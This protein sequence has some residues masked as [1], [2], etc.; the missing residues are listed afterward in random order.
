MKKKILFLLALLAPTGVGAQEA[1]QERSKAPELGM[2]LVEGEWQAPTPEGALRVLLDP[3][4]QSDPVAQIEPTTAV[5]RQVYE[6]YT[7]GEL[8]VVEEQ[9]VD[10]ILNGNEAQRKAA[11]LA[12]TV[13][14][15][16]EHD[17]PGIPYAGSRDAFI[18][19][20]DA[21][22]EQEYD[23]AR[24]YLA[25]IA[26]VGGIDYI[27]DLFETSEQPM[28]CFQPNTAGPGDPMPPE[29]EWYPIVRKELWC[30]AGQHLLGKEG[31]PDGT[32]FIR[33]C[34]RMR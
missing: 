4:M 25:D 1:E 26:W 29:S 7:S 21:L 5:L 6:S 13:A 10:L 27:R 30:D 32:L 9:L 2:V 16:L 11:R 34:T 3:R 15:D 20:F 24:D 17:D 19:V 33:L 23:R 22:H 18:R 14:A 31:G 8:D 28:P 12:L